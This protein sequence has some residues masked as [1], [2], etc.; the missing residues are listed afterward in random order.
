MTN[1]R[2]TKEP[3]LNIKNWECGVIFPVEVTG[4]SEAHPQATTTSDQGVPGWDVFLGKFPIPML[5][6]KSNDV[7]A[8][9]FEYGN[10]KP[11]FAFN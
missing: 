10:R 3:K 11:W 2:K 4:R 9:E 1:D 5:M 6:P 8:S 7:G